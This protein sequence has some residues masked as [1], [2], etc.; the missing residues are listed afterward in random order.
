M[1]RWASKFRFA[2]HA[3]RHEIGHE[4]NIPTGS[5]SGGTVRQTENCSLTL[6]ANDK[7]G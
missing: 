2:G 6:D 3:H 4:T 7:I 1:A 5:L